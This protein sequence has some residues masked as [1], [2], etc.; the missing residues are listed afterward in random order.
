[1]TRI[2]RRG[3]IVV[4][5]VVIGLIAIGLVA[6]R[7]RLPQQ[8]SVLDLQVSGTI[9]ERSLDDPFGKLF[10][11]KRP[12]LR[13]Y[14]EAL[15]RAAD[16]DRI[17][18]VLVTI[19]RPAAGFAQL[20]ELRDAILAF[21][22]SG[23]WA[24]AYTETVGEFSQGNGAYYLATACDSI[25]LAPPGD[26]NLTGLRAEVSFIRGTLDLLRVVPD[27]DHIGKYKNA[28]NFFTDKAMNEAYREAMDT[29]V[30]SVYGQFRAGIAEGRK[31]SE[32]EVQA[33]IDRGPFLAPQALEAGL[34]DRLGYRDELESDLK[35]HNDGHLNL[36]PVGRYLKGGRYYDRGP[37]LAV[38]Y[39]V[40]MVRRGESEHDPFTGGDNMGSDT[41]AKAIKNAREDDSIRAIV[42][43]VNSPGG[44]YVASDLIWREVSL[45]SGKKPI[46]ISMS[47]VAASGGYFVS[48]AADRIIAEPGT[49]TASIGVLA[50]K[51]ITTGMW[52]MAGVT[53]DS[54]QRG[55][56]ATFFSNETKYSP[57][58]R[59]VFRSWLE[60]IYDDFVTKAAQG[61]GKTFDEVDEIAQGR[62]WSGEDALRLG[63]IDGL[64]G[65]AT[66]IAQALDLA[67]LDP[68]SRVQLVEFPSPK[69]WFQQMFDRET[70]A[71]VFIDALRLRAERFIDEG[72]ITA[73][74]RAL[75][76]PFVP[77]IE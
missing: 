67:E 68:A 28:M 71:A 13:D 61:R 73:P 66:A 27:F 50:G 6:R 39:G 11:A 1:M 15:L 64:G 43:R 44:S 77:V 46:V 38:I 10:G 42:L 16:D 55:Q 45:T 57:T 47:N 49:I 9:A 21:R 48:M 58:E 22:E 4:A 35:E 51:M 72:G 18:G 32:D 17:S 36:I 23:K 60:R 37:R 20:Q 62:I 41:V 74:Q 29:L 52:N 2:A 14:V 19:D 12:A 59:A 63:L 69:S 31:M 5:V 7:G 70:V 56:H 65:M 30:G 53:S 24:V 54:V 34:V 3:L 76:I 75:E 8:G 25:W 26:V 33:L 40:G